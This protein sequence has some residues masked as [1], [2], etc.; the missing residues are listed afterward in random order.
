MYNVCKIKYYKFIV[1]TICVY[2]Y[3]NNILDLYITVTLC[4]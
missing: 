3:Y 2:K 1:I 4:I